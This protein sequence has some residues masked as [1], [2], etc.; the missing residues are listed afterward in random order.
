[1]QLHEQEA[2]NF[3][4]SRLFITRD[5]C[6]KLCLNIEALVNL[7]GHSFSASTEYNERSFSTGE[8]AQEMSILYQLRSPSRNLF[9]FSNVGRVATRDKMSHIK[10][11]EP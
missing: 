11:P 2:L 1:M 8:F 6:F 4:G 5:G 9:D 10:E 7:R 3:L